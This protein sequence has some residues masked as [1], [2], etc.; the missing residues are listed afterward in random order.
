MNIML[1]KKYRLLIIVLIITSLDSLSQCNKESTL[2]YPDDFWSLRTRHTYIAG[3][4]CAFFGSTDKDFF[5]LLKSYESPDTV[6]NIIKNKSLISYK[7]IWRYQ[8]TYDTTYLPDIIRIYDTVSDKEVKY[9]CLSILGFNKYKGNI[10]AKN[11]D[12]SCAKEWILFASS[13]PNLVNIDSV[14]NRIE[15]LI[16]AYGDYVYLQ[17]FE[18]IN[19]VLGHYNSDKPKELLFTLATNSNNNIIKLDAVICMNL[20]GDSLYQNRLVSSII[21]G[22][23][24][25]R[26]EIKKIAMIFIKYDLS[27][28]LDEIVLSSSSAKRNKESIL[29][30]IKDIKN[31][32]KL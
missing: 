20:I 23:E 13:Y 25:S 10:V 30:K 28:K 4:D 29:V 7:D 8:S 5:N 26:Y 2:M 19:T 1:Q 16:I 14:I 27:N 24:L 12:W 31:E 6:M 21:K 11:I 18:Q 32:C 22:K 9:A 3:N 15:T 17:Y